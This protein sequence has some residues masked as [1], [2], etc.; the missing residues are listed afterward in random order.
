MG[1]GPIFP[2]RC[3]QNFSSVAALA[4]L[5]PQVEEEK[6]NFHSPPCLLLAECQSDLTPEKVSVLKGW[7]FI[8]VMSYSPFSPQHLR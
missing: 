4:A 8:I 3:H 5:D 7:D 1:H 2:A 6:G